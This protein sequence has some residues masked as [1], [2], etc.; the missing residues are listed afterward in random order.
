MGQ[1]KNEEHRRISML[2]EI[3]DCNVKLAS[4]DVKLYGECCGIRSVM[5]DRIMML[6]MFSSS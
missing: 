5:S 6:D 1:L 2:R 4:V 3:S